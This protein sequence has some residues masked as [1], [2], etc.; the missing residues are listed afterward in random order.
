MG[1]IAADDS[2][3]SRS[4]INIARSLNKARSTSSYAGF[5]VDLDEDCDEVKDRE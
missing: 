1:Y 2:K 4:A 3:L 5:L